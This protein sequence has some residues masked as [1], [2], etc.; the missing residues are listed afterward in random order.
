[1]MVNEHHWLVVHTLVI[2]R[3]TTAVGSHCYG[4]RMTVFMQLFLLPVQCDVL[5]ICPIWL[6]AGDQCHQWRG[7]PL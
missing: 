2:W 6:D 7:D 5:C 3:S 1:M 4:N